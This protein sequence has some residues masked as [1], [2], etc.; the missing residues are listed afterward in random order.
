[1]F[2]L[3]KKNSSPKSE[4]LTPLVSEDKTISQDTSTDETTQQQS[5]KRAELAYAVGTD[6]NDQINLVVGL[7]QGFRSTLTM[8]E[9]GV[10][11]LIRQL[12]ANLENYD[13]TISER[14]KV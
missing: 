8:N 14:I 12:A 5:S 10:I 1:M 2:N 7:D 4:V 11:M 9:K 3:K 13:V 6:T